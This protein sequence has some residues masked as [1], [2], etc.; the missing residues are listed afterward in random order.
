MALPNGFTDLRALHAERQAALASQR[1]V[2][3]RQAAE[4]I[5]LLTT[6][7]QA[8]GYK[9]WKEGLLASAEKEHQAAMNAKDA[10]SMAIAL[11]A[12]SAYRAA[13]HAAENVIASSQTT[14]SALKR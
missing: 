11:G 7:V 13:A 14:I 12:E 2:A 1:E 9:V 3:T 4:T 10:H 5:N 6:I 8:P